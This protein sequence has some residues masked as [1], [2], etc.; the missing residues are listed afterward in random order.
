MNNWLVRP[1]NPPSRSSTRSGPGLQVQHIKSGFVRVTCTNPKSLEQ[2]AWGP[3]G[4]FKI[5]QRIRR[6]SGYREARH[7]LHLSLHLP[8]KISGDSAVC[9]ENELR[10]AFPASLWAATAWL[11]AGTA[12]RS[13][14]SGQQATSRP[15]AAPN[16]LSKTIAA[17][18]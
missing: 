10:S 2:F 14:L 5:A 1:T 7:S 11:A 8:L 18:I 6:C 17:T 4:G 3:L 9:S 12:L 16:A 13:H 15:P